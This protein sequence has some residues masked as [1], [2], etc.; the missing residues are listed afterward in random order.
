MYTTNSDQLQLALREAREAAFDV[1]GALLEATR[2][3]YER[4]FGRVP[5]AATLLKVVTSEPAFAWLRPLTA[6]IAD[7]DAL[8]ADPD[9]MPTGH[10]KVLLT[11]IH[12]LLR[13]DQ[14]GTAN[15]RRYCAVVQASPDV[16]VVHGRAQRSL[17]IGPVSWM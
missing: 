16:A 9:A 2:R 17:R 6:A 11:A 13:A 1:H 3:E 8:L 5:D 10:A 4:D 14:E 15:K 12:D 7:A